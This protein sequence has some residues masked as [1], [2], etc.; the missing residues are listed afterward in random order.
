MTAIRTPT[1][2]LRVVFN[3]D[4]QRTRAGELPPAFRRCGDRTGLM[5]IDPVGGG[6]WIGANDA[7]LI[8]AL[9][10]ANPVGQ[11]PLVRPT[12]RG[13]IVPAVLA[14]TTLGD[15]ESFFESF[16]AT[17]MGRFRLVAFQQ[18]DRL[19]A[20]SDGSS[21]IVSRSVDPEWPALWTSSSL[22]DEYVSRV[23]TRLFADLVDSSSAKQDEFHAHRWPDDLARSVLMIRADART[24]SRVT[25]CRSG[26]SI[27]MRHERVNESGEPVEH[28]AHELKVSFSMGAWS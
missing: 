5:P 13:A 26:E 22:G 14:L 19:E 12:S 2:I 21:V 27:S 1:D 3:R 17:R 20:V 6:S 9:L 4:E 23:R 16:D 11:G 8:A 24:V 10:N 25:L 7:G 28:T 15:V 18:F